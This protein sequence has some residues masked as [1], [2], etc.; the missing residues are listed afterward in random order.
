MRSNLKFTALALFAFLSAAAAC[1][2][3]RIGDEQ[4]P[5]VLEEP[6]EDASPPDTYPDTPSLDLHDE[7]VYEDETGRVCTT[8][9]F[10]D[11]DCGLD[12]VFCNG[13][14]FC[15][16]A[17]PDPLTDQGCCDVQPACAA[18]PEPCMEFSCIEAVQQ[19]VENPLDADDDGFPAR[20][21]VD[22]E[23]IEHD[24]G[25]TDCDDRAYAVHPGALESC[26]GLD[27][28]CDGVADEDAWSPAGGPLRLSAEAAYVTDADMAEL[29]GGWLVVWV[30]AA[31]VRAARVPSGAEE[32]ASHP[33]TGT[34]GAV[35]VEL[36]VGPAGGIFLFW[37][38]EGRS[39]NA[40]ALSD[41]DGFPVLS[42]VVLH[43]ETEPS[44]AATDLEAAASS[45]GTDA[46]VFFRSQMQGNS[47]I[48]MSVLDL[49][50][51]STV[52]PP[53]QRISQAIGFSG[54][55]AAAAGAARIA[56]AWEDERDGN[57]EI[58]TKTLDLSSGEG[59]RAY[60]I[61][62]APGD[63]SMPSIAE[64][65]DGFWVV[66]MDE[67]GG[68][69]NTMAASLDWEGAPVSYPIASE[70]MTGPSLYPRVSAD[71]REP[72]H[73][74]QVLILQ[75]VSGPDLKTLVLT[76]VGGGAAAIPGGTALHASSKTILK[77]T[78]SGGE[79]SR[80]L[81]WIEWE[82]ARSDLFFLEIA[83][84]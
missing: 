12:E 45:D 27:N 59:S 22:S 67:S 70:V 62:A 2:F 80:A 42:S 32:A 4:P 14:E 38:S 21:A 18:S 10:T 37:T 79:T 41:E 29:G 33:V 60:R 20:N 66:W 8:P 69:Y 82:Y 84:R 63:S 24:C 56:V 75:V 71:P 49:E 43:S 13:R 77:P 40:A 7:S 15:N 23:G 30:E 9:C 64:A 11:Q 76:G 51:P 57:K 74:D 3:E 44:S 53:P 55:A 83:C 39:V 5:D 31:G 48:Y 61:T 6:E 78:L 73:E 36:V 47:E 58:Y 68:P 28:D 1:S 46:A 72:G 19:C 81:V 26:D 65:G 16:M 17:E 50:S 25:G 52:P 34:D 35:E 54:Y